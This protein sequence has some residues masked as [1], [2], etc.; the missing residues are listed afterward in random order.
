MLCRRYGSVQLDFFNS[1]VLDYFEFL[2]S[3]RNT[4]GFHLNWLTSCTLTKKF[5]LNISPYE[6]LL[7]RQ[8]E[9]EE[10]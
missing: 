6:L 5:E 9:E 1:N 2:G 3:L 8:E 10:E 7:Y 4:V